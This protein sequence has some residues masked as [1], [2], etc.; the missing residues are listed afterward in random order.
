MC[1]GFHHM[2]VNFKKSKVIQPVAPDLNMKHISPHKSA[3]WCPHYYYLNISDYWTEY[4]DVD[5][6]TFS[7]AQ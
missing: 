7:D 6:G 1:V 4:T 3:I 5:Q 2:L